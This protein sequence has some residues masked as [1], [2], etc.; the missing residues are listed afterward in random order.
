MTKLILSLSMAL[1]APFALAQTDIRLE[2][3]HNKKSIEPRF[4][5][6]ETMTTERTE[7]RPQV[8]LSFKNRDRRFFREHGPRFWR[9]R[10]MHDR[11]WYM[12]NFG[13][14]NLRMIGNCWYYR[15]GDCF[16]PA[17]GYDP[18]C[19]YPNGDDPICVD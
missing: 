10:E 5:Q 3:K 14:S 17:F 12:I 16:W 7:V 18:M 1:V 4:E 9:S 19:H 11:N 13:E 2:E 8:R 6:R 15:Y